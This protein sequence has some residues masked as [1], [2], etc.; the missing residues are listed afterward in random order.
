[1]I[2]SFGLQAHNRK[3][4]SLV[5]DTKSDEDGGDKV[6]AKDA[7]VLQG[8]QDPEVDVHF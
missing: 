8:T 2:F 1:M 7:S 3:W 4:K 5:R 6:S